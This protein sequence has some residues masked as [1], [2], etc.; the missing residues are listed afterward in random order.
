MAGKT[1]TSIQGAL[2]AAL[3]GAALATAQHDS[4]KK[5]VGVVGGTDGKFTMGIVSGFDAK[6]DAG[7]LALVT[8]LDAQIAHYTEKLAKQSAKAE[9]PKAVKKEKKANPPKAAAK[10]SAVGKRSAVAKKK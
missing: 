6:R 3:M 2:R 8:P 9:Q 10:K 7:A 1:F 4:K 5:F